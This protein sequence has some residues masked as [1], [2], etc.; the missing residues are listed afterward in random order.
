[1]F[2]LTN[3]N[4]LRKFMNTKSLSSKQVC[5]VQQLFS[6]HFQIDYCQ[7]KSNR[8]ADALSQYLQ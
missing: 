6:Y 8:A 2:L 1:M 7:D 4:N 3:Y 5:K